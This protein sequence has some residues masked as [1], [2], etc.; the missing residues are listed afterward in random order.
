M[1]VRHFLNPVFSLVATNTPHATD[2]VL[3]LDA[4]F[5]STVTTIMRT[6]GKLGLRT[7]DP[8][9]GYAMSCPICGL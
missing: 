1:K 4:A 7:N 9:F 8:T 6:A 3:N 2:F 5:P